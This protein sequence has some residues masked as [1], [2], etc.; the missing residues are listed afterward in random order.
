MACDIH[1][2]A[3]VRKDGRWEK[4][5]HVFPNPNHRPDEP[6]SDWNRSRTDQPYLGSN[7]D[8]FAVLADVR[9]G[10]GVAG[11]PTGRGFKPIAYPRGVPADASPEYREYAAAWEQTGYPCHSHSWLTLRELLDYNWAGQSTIVYGPKTALE[12]DYEHVVRTGTPPPPRM[13]TEVAFVEVLTPGEYEDMLESGT[14]EVGKR[15]AICEPL[16]MTYLECARDFVE[17]TLPEL[18]KLGAPEDVRIVFF[19]DN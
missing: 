14:R 9:N 4:V 12:R 7:Y 13:I 6:E 5:G 1:I 8:V 3:E 18:G 17:G 10:Y 15:Y 19:F 2:F 16:E 11:V